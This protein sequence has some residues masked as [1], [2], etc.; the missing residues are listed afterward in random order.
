M[1]TEHVCVRFSWAAARQTRGN[2]SARTTSRHLQAR[3]DSFSAAARQIASLGFPICQGVS[4]TLPSS[5][6]KTKERADKSR[7][8]TPGGTVSEA[9]QSR[10]DRA[11]RTAQLGFPGY[12]GALGALGVTDNGCHQ[13][14]QMFK[15]LYLMKTGSTHFLAVFPQQEISRI[16]LAKEGIF[17]VLI[18]RPVYLRGKHIST[19]PAALGLES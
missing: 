2:N 16:I 1:S 11:V 19:R 10:E 14:Q 9:G 5:L 18:L 4:L 3:S 8:D 15:S 6:E 7:L 17:H 12:P 13:K